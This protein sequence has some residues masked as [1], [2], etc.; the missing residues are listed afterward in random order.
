MTRRCTTRRSTPAALPLTVSPSAPRACAT[1]GFVPGDD[2]A[3]VGPC[4]PG[5]HTLALVVAVPAGVPC[6][7]RPSTGCRHYDGPCRCFTGGPA[8]TVSAL[9]LRKWVVR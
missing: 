3:V 5:F 7:A 8:P 1:C 2:E 6:A 4:V 9:V